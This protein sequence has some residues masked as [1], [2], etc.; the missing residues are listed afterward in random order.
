MGKTIRCVALISYTVKRT[1][2][3]ERTGDVIYLNLFRTPTVVLNS[4]EAATDVLT[5]RSAK[6][7]DRPR[8][9]LLGEL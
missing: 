9:I 4:L 2:P 6:H 5:K 3:V 7:S 8:M 1:Y